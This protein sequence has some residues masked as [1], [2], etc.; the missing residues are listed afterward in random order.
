MEEFDLDKRIFKGLKDNPGLD[1]LRFAVIKLESC[2][3]TKSISFSEVT[4]EYEV[5]RNK[6]NRRPCVF[7]FTLIFNEGVSFLESLE[8]GSSDDI[9]NMEPH[10]KEAV[11]RLNA[12]YKSIEYNETCLKK[13]F[14]MKVKGE[15]MAAT[16]TDISITLAEHLL[17]KLAP[18]ES[19]KIDN[20]ARGKKSCR[21]GCKV[22]PVFD[23]T[24]IGH[25][26]VWHGFI[27]IVF[28]SHL[29]LHSMANTVL[30]IEEN[31][32]KK[33]RVDEQDETND[34]SPGRKTITEVKQALPENI[35]SQ[36]IAQT[37]VF[38]L[39]QKQKHPE[40]LHHMIPNI[41]IS[42][43]KLEIMMYDSDNDVLLCSNP[44]HIFNLDLPEN[45]T[46][47]DE[48]V[49]IIWMVLHYRI[50]GTGLNKA[51]PYLLERCKSNFTQLV[52]SKWDIYSKSLKSC[53]PGFP[54]VQKWPL[55]ELIQCGETL[56]F[57]SDDF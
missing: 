49:V 38:S 48:T 1:M 53:V 26:Q 22:T 3:G 39:L 46:L 42:P 50:F 34:D 10:M 29:G 9:K 55:G 12:F 57:E 45:R 6:T 47:I 17:G 44:I 43:E 23:G 41:V 15:E 28:S 52:A 56:K 16:E 33:R 25:E 36:A 5:L 37:I 18:G 4:C 19:Y 13:V 8:K 40:F 2:N 7:P 32:S 21:C 24:G 54:S 20:K 30:D 11:L 31:I 27:D 35:L 14:D 51:T